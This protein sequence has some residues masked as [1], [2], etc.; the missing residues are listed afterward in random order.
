MDIKLGNYRISPETNSPT[1]FNLSIIGSVEDKESKN[2]GKEKETNLAYGITLAHAVEIIAHRDMM[3]KEG[4]TTLIDW[5]N[6]YVKLLKSLE[7][8]LKKILS[9]N[10][11][12]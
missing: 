8:M 9:S 5:V 4:V 12:A 7:D 1:Q 10:V 3:N 6:Q 11:K 2:F